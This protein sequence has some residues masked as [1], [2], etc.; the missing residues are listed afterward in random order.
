MLRMSA[1]SMGRFLYVV[2]LWRSVRSV[3]TRFDL[4]VTG[5]TVAENV[6]FFRLQRAMSLRDL[7]AKLRE[8]GW[9]I[10]A[11]GLMKIEKGTRRVDVDDLAALALA[12][13]VRPNDLLTQRTWPPEELDDE[14]KAE[15]QGYAKVVVRVLTEAKKAG[16]P[17]ALVIDLAEV[18]FD[19]AE[20]TEIS[21]DDDA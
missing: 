17:K 18:V 6:K 14:R 19:F 7:E 3:P 12:F 9:P 4:G 1:K 15:L 5:Q 20:A 11:S 2:K 13:G 10:L 21:T 8:V 16:F